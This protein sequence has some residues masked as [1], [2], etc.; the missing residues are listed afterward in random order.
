MS[1]QVVSIIGIIMALIL[2][3]ANLRGQRIGLSDGVR[4]A[5]LWAFLLVAAALVFS[6]L[7]W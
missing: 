7:G 1:D 4:M 2:V 6:V 3:T 5:A